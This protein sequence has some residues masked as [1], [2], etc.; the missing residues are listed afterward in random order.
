MDDE[1]VDG[2]YGLGPDEFVAARTALAKRRAAEGDQEAAKEVRALRR[3]TLV[4]W[5]ANQLVRRDPAGVEALLG[6][7]HRLRES[8][9]STLGRRGGA[10]LRAAMA[11]RRA[12]LDHLLRL[13]VDVLGE[14]GGAHREELSA[15]LLASSADPAAGEQLRRGQLVREVVTP[16]GF[17]LF[18]DAEPLDSAH[19]PPSQPARRHGSGG[20]TAGRKA[21]AERAKAEAR[22]VA[23]EAAHAVER[24]AADLT[25]AEEAVQLGRS[26]VT[27]LEKALSSAREAMADAEDRRVSLNNAR[28]EAQWRAEEAEAERARVEAAMVDLSD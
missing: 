14:R 27:A 25:A 2:L 10:E 12:S 20:S 5:A 8:Q 7:G 9:V 4:A 22:H 11:A 3:P 24:A 28:T 26:D 18:G 19:E 15:M 6:A 17:E 13:G 16:S 23:V 21:E 1:E